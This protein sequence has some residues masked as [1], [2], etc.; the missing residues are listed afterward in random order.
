MA[1][2]GESLMVTAVQWLGSSCSIPHASSALRDA[3]WSAY[4]TCTEEGPYEPSSRDGK[5]G[6]PPVRLTRSL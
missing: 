3:L 2:A 6:L 5:M 4:R 1:T